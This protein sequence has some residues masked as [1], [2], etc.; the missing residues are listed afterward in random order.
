MGKSVNGR[1]NG[2]DWT[3]TAA[4]MK[5]LEKTY[6]ISLLATMQLVTTRGGPQLHVV[7]SASWPDP[8]KSGNTGATG[9]GCSYPTVNAQTMACAMYN[10][11]HQL[12]HHLSTDRQYQNGMPF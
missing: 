9:V 11:C 3:D 12:D 6:S 10:L 1:E 8:T 7:L 2:P 4:Y 5:E